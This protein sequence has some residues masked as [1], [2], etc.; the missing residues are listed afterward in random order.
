MDKGKRLDILIEQRK[1]IDARTGVEIPTNYLWVW[2]DH[3][4]KD[5]IQE[6]AGV[7]NVIQSHKTQYG[8]SIDPR[9]DIDIVT[10]N[11]K[12]AIKDWMASRD[13]TS[14]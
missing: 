13:E 8:V 1:Q 14:S 3:G 5:V 9:Y 6:I 7:M 2:A 12:I 11:I 4:C 10:N